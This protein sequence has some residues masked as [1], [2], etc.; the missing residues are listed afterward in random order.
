MK[1]M[2]L[3]AATALTIASCGGNSSADTKTTGGDS[4]ADNTR[5]ADTAGPLK[6][7]VP[8]GSSTSTSDFSKGN[9]LPDGSTGDVDSTHVKTD[10]LYKKVVKEKK[11]K[12]DSTH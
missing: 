7:T 1:Y 9:A 3:L 11:A 5:N 6:D 4:A 10:S 8:T 12:K 2:I